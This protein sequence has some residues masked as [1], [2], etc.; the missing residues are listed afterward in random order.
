MREP[1]IPVALMVI[2][3]NDNSVVFDV[4]SDLAIGVLVTFN[5]GIDPTC[6]LA[7]CHVVVLLEGLGDVVNLSLSEFTMA[8][9]EG[10][11]RLFGTCHLD[12]GVEQAELKVLHGSVQGFF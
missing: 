5:E 9:D 2:V 11:G 3:S 7:S 1:Q 6:D 12:D 4:G 8:F 10:D